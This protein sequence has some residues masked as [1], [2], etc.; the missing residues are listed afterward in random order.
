MIGMKALRMLRRLWRQEL[1]QGLVLA[2]LGMLVILGFAAMAV[3][4][5]YWLAQKGEV[6]KA[7]DAAALA[8][9]WE[10]PDDSVAAT[11]KAQEYLLKNGVDASKGDTI[12]I[13]FRRTYI[14][15]PTKWDTIVVTVDRPAQAWFARAFGLE[16]ALIGN[17][18]AAA[19]KGGGGGAFTP[20]DVVEVL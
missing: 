13:T 10:L 18:H 3:D 7:V 2:A 15:D 14:T 20:V 6:Q 16:D 17:V 12:S 9:A 8:G 1:G 5:G 19:A 11:A 4:V